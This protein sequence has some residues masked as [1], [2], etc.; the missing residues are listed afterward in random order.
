MN[1]EEFPISY[2]IFLL[3]DQLDELNNVKSFLEDQLPVKV[4]P[5]SN[6]DV[7]MQ[8][9]KKHTSLFSAYIL[10]IEMVGQK[11]SGIQVAETIRSQP[12]S[13]LVPIIFLTSHAHFGGGVLQNIHYYD[14]FSKAV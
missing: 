2:N 11:Y 13:T 8:L 6:S 3:D 4:V 10:D 1:W 5:V 7:A 9:V 14:F 12:R